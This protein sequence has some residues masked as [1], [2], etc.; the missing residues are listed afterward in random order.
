M[1]ERQAL[2]GLAAKIVSA[3]ISNNAIAS[4]QLPGLIRQVF[5]ALT[6]VEQATAAPTKPEPAVPVRRSVVADHI[7]CLDCGKHFSMLRR[8]LMTDHKMTPS[9]TA[10]VGICHARTHLRHLIMRRLDRHWRRRLVWVTSVKGHRRK[11][12]A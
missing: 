6:T 10:S 11:Q 7:V 12:R 4:D 5:N 9:S 2:L 8:H 3:H 1:A